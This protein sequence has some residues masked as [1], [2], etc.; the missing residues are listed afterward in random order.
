MNQFFHF[1][2]FFFCCFPLK[3]IC[4]EPLT[5]FVYN[6]FPYYSCPMHEEFSGSELEATA[7]GLLFMDI[8]NATGYVEG[9]D[10]KFFCFS[11]YTIGTP[12][13]MPNE[14]FMVLDE[15]ITKIMA[16]SFIPT[17]HL[18]MDPFVLMTF[19][20]EDPW[21]MVMGID[22]KIYIVIFLFPL[23]SGLIAAYLSDDIN[24]RYYIFHYICCLFL[25]VDI[26]IK[27]G[28]YKQVISSYW[29][30]LADSRVRDLLRIPDFSFLLLRGSG[31]RKLP[32]GIF[33]WK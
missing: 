29:L 19:R 5:I 3:T 2:V 28:V 4:S 24:Y 10:F 31:R 8:L 16:D 1:S 25:Q 20:E 9:E 22:W 27:F 26:T 15:W 14:E 23:V 7:R 21:R 6:F 33:W 12:G 18:G 17:N 11:D 30:I 32:S 13:F